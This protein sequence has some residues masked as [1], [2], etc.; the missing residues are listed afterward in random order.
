M[1]GLL[2]FWLVRG[3]TVFSPMFNQRDLINNPQ[4]FMIYEF[5]GKRRCIVG[6]NV[7]ES[8]GT[9]VLVSGHFSGIP[10]VVK[11][12]PRA[13]TCDVNRAVHVVI[14]M[15]SHMT[16]SHR[17]E[18]FV[19][20]V[21]TPEAEINTITIKKRI[22]PLAK[23]CVVAMAFVAGVDR[24]VRK[25]YKPWSFV[26]LFVSECERS[27]QPLF[28]FITARVFRRDCRE[29]NHTPVKGIPKGTVWSTLAIRHV[30]TMLQWHAI[31]FAW[32][33]WDDLMVARSNHVR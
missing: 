27:F 15:G 11:V 9:G 8:P 17:V 26:S 28:L 29:M 6:H 7:T 4:C 22:K 24:A 23:F 33:V 20:V 18:P 30:E 12:P 1:S 31:L 32:V 13:S 2:W 16:V 19:R 5:H 14:V 21:M 10:T 25:K 3:M